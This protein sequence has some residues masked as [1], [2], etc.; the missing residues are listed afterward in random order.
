M[1]GPGLAGDDKIRARPPVKSGIFLRGGEKQENGEGERGRRRGGIE[2]EEEEEGESSA[3]RGGGGRT[4]ER[5]GWRVQLELRY[6]LD[7]LP[8]PFS[9]LF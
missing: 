3:G 8:F 6:G 1:T 5:K 2:E 4:A 9:L 7:R